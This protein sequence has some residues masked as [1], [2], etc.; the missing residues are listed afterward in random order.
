MIANIIESV[1]LSS[2]DWELLR[3]FSS[4]LISNNWLVPDATPET[5]WPRWEAIKEA[6][7]KMSAAK[8]AQ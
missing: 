3:R 8:A 2:L 4:K 6:K 7:L 1:N 5:L